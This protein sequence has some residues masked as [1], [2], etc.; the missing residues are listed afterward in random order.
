MTGTL[1]GDQHIFLTISSS[2]LLRMRN[3]SDKVCR[4]QNTHF[5]WQITPFMSYCGII[6]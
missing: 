4:D 2:F 5:E 3:I 1:H 6:A